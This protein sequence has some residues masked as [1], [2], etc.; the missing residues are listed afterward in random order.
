MIAGVKFGRKPKLSPYQRAEAIKNANIDRTELRSRYLDDLAVELKP[1]RTY[2]AWSW[3]GGRT[4]HRLAK[5]HGRV[6]KLG[7]NRH[8]RQFNP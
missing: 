5:Q 7:I 1:P 8:P 4:L 3:A 2:L 6:R